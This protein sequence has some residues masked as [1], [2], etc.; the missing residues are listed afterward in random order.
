MITF[1]IQASTA[2]AAKCTVHFAK[3]ATTWIRSGHEGE[4]Q[5]NKLNLP[6][7]DSAAP[8]PQTQSQQ[9]FIAG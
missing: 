5:A 8:S 2:V 3:Y 9:P 7:A 4:A 6:R 1:L